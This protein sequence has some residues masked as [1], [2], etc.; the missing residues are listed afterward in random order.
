[1]SK[2]L[3]FGWYVVRCFSSHEKKVKD[4]LDINKIETRPMFYPMSAHKHLEKISIPEEEQEALLLNRH[5]FMIPS[6]PN[7]SKE[8]RQHII[9]T[10]QKLTKLSI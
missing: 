4:F 10:L 1:M 9:Q 3:D 5:C 7:V 6:H 8:E 2:E